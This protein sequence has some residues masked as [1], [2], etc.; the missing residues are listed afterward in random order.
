MNEK[1]ELAVDLIL[2]AANARV[3]ICNEYDLAERIEEFKAFQ[4]LIAKVRKTTT[5]QQLQTALIRAGWD[6]EFI[7]N[8]LNGPR[9]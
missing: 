5:H 4:R 8:V 6:E 1:H 9:T 2:E 3:E 7:V